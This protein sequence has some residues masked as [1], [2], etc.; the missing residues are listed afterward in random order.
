MSSFIVEEG[1]FLHNSILLG[2]GITFLYDCLRIFRRVF[3][4]H[5]FWVSVEDF[6]YWIF[7]SV[8]IFYLLYYENNGDFR[9]FAILGTL[10]GMFLFQKTLSPFF[11]KYI[12][13]LMLWMKKVVGKILGFL[14]RP[15]GMAARAAGKKAASGN[16]KIRRVARI[17]KKRLTV[18]GRTAKMEL[19]KRHKK[20]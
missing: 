6:F 8:S 16:R 5:I 9:W 18:W 7:V 17:L 13:Q 11:V 4:H 19:C 10:A 20:V 12:S 14:A 3:P 15:F 2:V 1:Q